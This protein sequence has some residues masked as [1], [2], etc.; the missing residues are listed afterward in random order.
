[1]RRSPAPQP[2]PCRARVCQPSRK[3]VEI[4][5]CVAQCVQAGRSELIPFISHPLILILIINDIILIINVNNIFI[6]IIIIMAGSATSIVHAPL[7][8]DCTHATPLA[9]LRRRGRAQAPERIQG[10]GRG[11]LDAIARR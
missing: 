8:P 10:R 9:H 6:L 11:R 5:G 4:C 3:L 1:V 2:I 7:S